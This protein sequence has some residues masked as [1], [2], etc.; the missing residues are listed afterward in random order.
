M[1][2]LKETKYYLISGITHLIF[3]SF[4]IFKINSVHE[5]IKPGEH[6]LVSYLQ[7]EKTVVAPLPIEK[8][9]LNKII[10]PKKQTIKK[11]SPPKTKGEG[12]PL[13]ELTAMLHAA[14]AAH[15]HYPAAALEMQ[16][17]G[18]VTV[19][20][21]LYTNG[22]ISNLRIIHSSGTASIDQAGISAVN[23]AAPFALA[24]KYLKAA[25]DYQL[26]VVFEL[27]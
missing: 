15:Q 1:K 25:Q 22:T 13:T 10:K 23:E 21:T 24:Q 9:S 11:I 8:K 6:L 12:A 2:L 14:I 20:F 27:T 7:Q 17:E 18:R 19:A 26:D 4:I 16:R 3:I 5:V